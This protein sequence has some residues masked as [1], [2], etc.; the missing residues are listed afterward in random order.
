MQR[1]FLP[2]SEQQVPECS[3]TSLQFPKPKRQGTS[4]VESGRFI[5]LGPPAPNNRVLRLENSGGWDHL[6]LGSRAKLWGVAQD[7][8]DW[9]RGGR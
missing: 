9:D 7:H 6:A 5:L 4:Y 8:K 3:Q 2:R 1:S